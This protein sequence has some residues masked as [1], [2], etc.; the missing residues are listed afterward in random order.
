M[1]R[2]TQSTNNYYSTLSYA[3]PNSSNYKG[4]RTRIMS[5]VENFVSNNTS[6]LVRPMTGNS[7]RPSSSSFRNTKGKL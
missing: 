6:G 2:F 5:T 4:A 7:I 3:R 1:T